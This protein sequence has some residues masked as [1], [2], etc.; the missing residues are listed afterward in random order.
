MPLTDPAMTATPEAPTVRSVATER[1]RSLLRKA[2]RYARAIAGDLRDTARYAADLPSAW[3]MGWD[4]ATFRLL[5]FLWK[6]SDKIRHVRIRPDTQLSYRQNK[7]DI[8]SIHEIWFQESYR[9]PVELR[10]RVLVDVGANI[11][12]TSLW[13]A[14]RYDCQRLIAVEPSAGNAAVARENFS[15]N[16][17]DAVVH[18]AAAGSRDGDAKFYEVSSSTNGRLVFDDENAEVPVGVVRAVPVRVISMATILASLP[19][20]MPIDL[21]KVDIEGGEQALLTGD[22]SWLARVKA[23]L[24][25]FHP[26]LVEYA[27]LVGIIEQSG[28]RRVH[29][30]ITDQHG[31]NTL[32][33]FVR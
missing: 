26:S 27:R 29:S 31:G 7:G 23:L 5:E 33:L 12:M 8:Y 28:L 13:L 11:G 32:E 6:P 3:R 30:V 2:A 15:R 10:P 21:M 19:A 24:I 14:K 17:I 4:L 25:E 1:P 18:E 9:L 22:V 20:E 16:G